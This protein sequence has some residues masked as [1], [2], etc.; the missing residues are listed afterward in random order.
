MTAACY[1]LLCGRAAE[2]I[3]DAAVPRG[4]KSSAVRFLRLI[5]GPAG[6]SG[7]LEKPGLGRLGCTWSLLGLGQV[8]WIAV[9]CPWASLLI[10]LMIAASLMIFLAMSSE[11]NQAYS[12]TYSLDQKF[13]FLISAY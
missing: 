4:E 12:D 7:G 11:N 13:L 3:E 6:G 10:E 9:V 5:L 8:W 2:L 1:R